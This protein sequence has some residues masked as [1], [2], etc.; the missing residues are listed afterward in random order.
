MIRFSDAI[1]K[2]GKINS[3]RHFSRIYIHGHSVGGT[4]PSLLEAM[5]CGCRIVAHRNPFN[6]SVLGE[7]ARYFST[8]GELTSLLDTYEHDHY[9]DLTE[10]N[11]QMVRQEYNWDAVTDAYE[12]L[13]YD[14]IGSE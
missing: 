3:L 8:S 12:K 14:A 9:L 2:E 6:G 4:N 11:L 10:R 7:K 5:A 13:F 1:Y